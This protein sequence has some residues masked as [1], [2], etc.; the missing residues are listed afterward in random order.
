MSQQKGPKGQ[1]KSN[2]DEFP[3]QYKKPSWFVQ[4]SQMINHE[5][6]GD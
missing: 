6:R 3:C 5:I 4:Q 2:R 1:R